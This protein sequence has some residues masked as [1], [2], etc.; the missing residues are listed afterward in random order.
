MRGRA[1]Y[2]WIW[3]GGL[4]FPVALACGTTGS[5]APSGGMDA[6]APMTF[7][8]TPPMGSCGAV[9]QEQAIEGFTHVD[10]CSVV[11]Y[12]TKPPS[13]G[14]HYAVWAA[15]QSYDAAIPE[16]FWVHNLEHGAVVFSYNCPGGCAADV[17]AAQALI[18][19]LPADPLCDPTAG[20]PVTRMLMTPDPNLDVRFAASAWGWTLRADC[21]DSA[22]FGAFVQA[23]YGNGREPI[24]YN[25]DIPPSCTDP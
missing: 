14:N 15:Y 10:V 7:D 21:F 20:D 16:G 5:D 18:D 22:T 24:C 8:A 1:T 6:G 11:T 25:G 12:E 23:H 2:S 3:L 9:V 13:S 17:A 4:A 19:G